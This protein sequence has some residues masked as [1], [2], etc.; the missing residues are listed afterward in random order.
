MKDWA[1]ERE[2]I[3]D[4]FESTQLSETARQ[5]TKVFQLELVEIFILPFDE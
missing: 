5:I 1:E 3:R 4:C 2:K